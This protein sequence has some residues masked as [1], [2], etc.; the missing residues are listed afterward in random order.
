MGIFHAGRKGCVGRFGNL[1]LS[2]RQELEWGMGQSDFGTLPLQFGHTGAH[3]V[4]QCPFFMLCKVKNTQLEKF[5]RNL[6][7]VTKMQPWPSSIL[8]KQWPRF[9]AEKP[10]WWIQERKGSLKTS[11]YER[12]IPE[13]SRGPLLSFQMEKLCQKG[14]LPWSASDSTGAAAF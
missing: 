7:A 14:G 5:I 12:F 4:I 8:K 13:R 9:G 6:G 11:V 1:A 3:R 10:Q 2:F